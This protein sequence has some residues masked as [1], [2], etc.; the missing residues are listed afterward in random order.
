MNSWGHDVDV[1]ERD[2]KPGGLLRYGIPNMKLDKEVVERR[3]DIMQE[4]G[5]RFIC[6]VNAGSDVTYDTLDAEYDAVIVAVG[7]RK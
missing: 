5:I 3:I 1:Y 2:A 7:A 6:D 4:A